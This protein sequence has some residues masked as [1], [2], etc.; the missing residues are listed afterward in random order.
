MGGGFGREDT[1]SSTSLPEEM[2]SPL[3]RPRLQAFKDLWGPGVIR[4]GGKGSG[5]T[6]QALQ[7]KQAE[8]RWRLRGHHFP[9]RGGQWA[10]VPVQEPPVRTC[11][12]PAP[13]AP[14]RTAASAGSR[15]T[16]RGSRAAAHP[17]GKVSLR[18]QAGPGHSNQPWCFCRCPPAHA[19][20]IL[21]SHR[22]DV[23][24]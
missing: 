3:T 10:P 14:A 24:D 23:R 9:L 1:L 19:V 18:C 5:W 21:L 2:C 12:P 20:P 16:T 4:D 7:R 15:R 17:A 13:A 8:G 11:W 22:P 6:A